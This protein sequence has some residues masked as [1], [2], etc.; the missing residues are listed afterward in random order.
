[1]YMVL[2]SRKTSNVTHFTSLQNKIT[3]HISCQFTPHHFTYLHSIHTWIP[4]LVTTILTILH[5]TWDL[6]MLK[7]CDSSE[8]L[9]L[10][11]VAY[12]TYFQQ[13]IFNSIFVSSNNISPY[14]QTSQKALQMKNKFTA[15][16]RLT[17]N[18]KVKPTWIIRMLL[19]LPR[20]VTTTP[21]L[22]GKM[23]WWALPVTENHFETTTTKKFNKYIQETASITDTGSSQT[24]VGAPSGHYV[25]KQICIFCLTAMNYI[26]SIVSH[27]LHL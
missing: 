11:H 21:T 7:L 23:L 8:C 20:L 25:S 12:F 17:T 26:L 19:V 2:L 3:S 14:F 13:T 10:N 15:T 4:L 22:R 27:L 24:P 1:M 9:I 16:I 18:N 5:T 6:C